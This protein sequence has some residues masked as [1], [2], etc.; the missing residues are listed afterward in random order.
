MWMDKK[1]Q[2][3]NQSWTRNQKER[4]QILSIF[5]ISKYIFLK[6]RIANKLSLPY[7]N[8]IIESTFSELES[9]FLIEMK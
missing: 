1:K 2:K 4:R 5:I 8:F 9:R 3:S 7:F 6:I